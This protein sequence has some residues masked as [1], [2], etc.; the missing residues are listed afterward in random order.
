MAT[1][2]IPAA[3]DAL[4]TILRAA[5]TLEGVVIFDGPPTEEEDAAEILAVG[6]RGSEEPGAE[7]VQDFAYAGA[8]RRDEEFTIGGYLEVWSGDT[9]FGPIRR[10]A[11]ELLAAVEDAIRATGSQ[12]MAPTLNGTVQW[13]HLTAMSLQQT[14]TEDG[15]KAGIP[16]AVSCRARI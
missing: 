2:A 4:L 6:W 9:D 5:G 15:I 13:G 12:P 11:F 7:G 16:F 10:R 8:R 14:F 3:I 1:S